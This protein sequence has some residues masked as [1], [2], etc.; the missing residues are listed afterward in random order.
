MLTKFVKTFIVNMSDFGQKIK[1]IREQKGEP[2]R[3]VAYHLGID[4]AILSKIENG[5]RKATKKQVELIAKYFDF[6][7]KELVIDWLSDK[8]IY[9][10][11]DEEFG[12]EA[13][14]VAE[15]KIKYLK[16]KR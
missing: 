5:K 4:Q 11:E 13:L 1:N 15:E 8:I 10:V 16:T 12:Y 7:T 3:I 6:S 14:K 2:L 9:D